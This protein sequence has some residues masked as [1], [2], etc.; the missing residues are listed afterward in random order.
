MPQKDD[1][2]SY[3]E[4]FRRRIRWRDGCLLVQRSFWIAL[5][6]AIPIQV[7]GRFWPLAHLPVWVLVP[8]LLWLVLIMGFIWLQPMSLMLAARRVD[9]ELRLK[10]RLSTAVYLKA[11]IGINLED[12]GITSQT[13]PGFQSE[14]VTLQQQ[15]ALA[16][17]RSISPHQAFPLQWK[18]KSLLLT[19]PLVVTI[20]VLAIL[21]NPMDAIL[22]KRA[23]LA[24]AIKDQA[25]QVEKI[26][27]DLQKDTNEQE[28]TPEERQELLR[29]LEELAQ[30]LRQNPDDQEQALADLSKLEEALRQKL[31]PNIEQRQAALDSLST[32]MH[33]IAEKKGWS[34]EIGNLEQGLEKMAEEWTNLS[35]SEQDVLAKS[36]SQLAGQAAQ[37]G[38]QN[39]A[40][41]L[42]S[43]AQSLQ[44][45]KS[46][47][48]PGN[49]ANTNIQAVM[50]TVAQTQKSLATQKSLQQAL[51]SLQASRQA[52]AQ[53]GRNTSGSQNPDQ[54]QGSGQSQGAP[55]GGGGTRADTL[56]P[57]TGS[58]SAVQPRGQAQNV[59][60]EK[61]NSQVYVPVEKIQGSAELFIEGQDT[62]QGETQASQQ[63][64][65]LP[66]ASGKVLI[67]YHQ[68]YYTYL[69]TANQ[70]MERSLIPPALQD[71]VRQYFS[72][73][74]P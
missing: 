24:S 1:L 70:A 68:V 14:L 2:H 54:A 32:Q 72:Q 46:K 21:P 28:L 20:A 62:G 39:L 18:R 29:R 25:V 5:A 4:D 11:Q 51:A 41:A 19:A 27:E 9:A 10:E 22:A 43:L 67:P 61:L 47:G 66:G 37:A 17:A 63:K 56:P 16:S 15:D 26:K 35:P 71:F 73:L 64:Y 52:I 59:A 13:Q 65:S 12:Q 44:T 31:D 30:K 55:G 74:Q 53:A 23:A 34:N 38:D 48:K 57:A 7:V 69:N 42:A 33:D 40:Q 8:I 49:N 60:A 50:Q 58:G 3:L 36:L 6:V 45:G